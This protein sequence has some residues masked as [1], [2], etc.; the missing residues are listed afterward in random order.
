MIWGWL[1]QT[2]TIAMATWFLFGVHHM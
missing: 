2:E 1:T